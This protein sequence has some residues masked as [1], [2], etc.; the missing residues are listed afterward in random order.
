[1][2]RIQESVLAAGFGEEH[3]TVH[4]AGK[5]ENLFVDRETDGIALSTCCGSAF[6]YSMEAR[7]QLR[8]CCERFAKSMRTIIINSPEDDRMLIVAVI[9]THPDRHRFLPSQ[10]DLNPDVIAGAVLR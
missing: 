4:V 1:V 8:S 9:N 7:R 2:L 3:R 6:S 5:Y 10:N